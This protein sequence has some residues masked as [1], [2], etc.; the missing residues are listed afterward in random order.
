M[1]RSEA[2]AIL[3]TLALSVAAC[4]PATPPP[5]Q[6]VAVVITTPAERAPDSRQPEGRFRCEI[7]VAAM[8]P[9]VVGEA[10]RE[11]QGD[12][13]DEAWAQACEALRTQQGIDCHDDERVAQVSRQQKISV[14]N[15]K[16]TQT[17]R[18]VVRPKLAEVEGAASSDV[19]HEEACKSA[20]ESA[21]QQAPKGSECSAL[22]LYCQADPSDATLW[23]CSSKP[24]PKPA[25]DPIFGA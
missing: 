20:V 17:L 22:G 16:M 7:E 23:R 10:S 6:P 15:G 24:R 1:T 5:D 14:I 9:E 12:L 11:G 3:A 8:G 25:A 21:C 13:N 2:A 18:I 4:G 19:S